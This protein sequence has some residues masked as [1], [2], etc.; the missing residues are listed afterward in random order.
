M[1]TGWE[2]GGGVSHV[3]ILTA[4]CCDSFAHGMIR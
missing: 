2:G 1:L 4:A 3:E